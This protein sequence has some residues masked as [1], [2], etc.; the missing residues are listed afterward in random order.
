MRL[1][2]ETIGEASRKSAAAADLHSSAME[3]WQLVNEARARFSMPALRRSALLGVAARL[4]ARDMAERS[5]RNH[6]SPEGCTLFQRVV[7]FLEYPSGGVAENLAAGSAGP[8]G[9]ARVVEAWLD[10][11]A[12]RMN[13]LHPEY[14]E[15]GIAVTRGPDGSLHWVQVFGDGDTS[16]AF[17]KG[18]LGC[19]EGFVA[20]ELPR[21]EEGSQK[22]SAFACVSVTH[23]AGP[24]PRALVNACKSRRAKVLNTALDK[25]VG[26]D[27]CDAPRWPRAQFFSLQG[28]GFCLKPARLDGITGYCVDGSLALGPFPESLRAACRAAAGRAK[29]GAERGALHP[30]FSCESDAWPAKVLHSAWETID[31]VR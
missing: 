4:H 30:P 31:I 16:P 27:E 5:Y 21:D 11:P 6:T 18:R 28:A 7:S 23:V 26:P 14:V 3:A 9:A 13:I 24:F 17:E 12:H 15:T 19:A 8:Q 10:S 20:L 1:A 29:P 22:E 2:E 25:S